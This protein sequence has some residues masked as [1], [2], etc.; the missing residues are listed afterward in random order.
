MYHEV[1]R[2]FPWFPASL[3]VNEFPGGPKELESETAPLNDIRI[4]AKR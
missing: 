1:F 3:S 4:E 2:R